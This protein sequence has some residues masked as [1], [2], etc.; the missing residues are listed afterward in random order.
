MFLSRPS[1]LPRS[2]RG[3]KAIFLIALLVV[4]LIVST[5][6]FLTYYY[7]QKIITGEL[8][9]NLKGGFTAAQLSLPAEP[10]EKLALSA[11]N[12]PSFGP[13]KSPLQI[14]EFADFGCAYS[15]EAAFILREL[16]VKYPDKF[17]FVFRDFPLGGSLEDASFRA[18]EA[19]RC[20]DKQARQNLAA[21]EEN[22]GGQ[23]KF[24]AMHD[25]IFQNQEHLTDLDLKMYA[26]Q[27]GLDMAKFNTCFDNHQTQ[28][29]VEIDA[30]DGKAAG[31][32]GTP[33]FFINGIKVEGAL[34]KEA[35]EKVIA[36]IK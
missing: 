12:S 1:S 24:W 20:A 29:A 11:S 33:T 9:G 13:V 8:A 7:Y 17:Y 16:M 28:E 6:G 18:A 2:R 4:L 10:K 25:K 19:A 36:S 5:I 15:Q 3:W 26:L 14:V 27:S 30:A 21:E 31:V 35:W 34:P 23:G 22:L 32:R